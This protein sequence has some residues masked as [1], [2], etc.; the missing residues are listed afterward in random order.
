M[1]QKGIFGLSVHTFE[2]ATYTKILLTTE[3]MSL[4]GTGVK[5]TL[6]QGGGSLCHCN[7]KK[8]MGTV[9]ND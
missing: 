3:N 7:K 2:S 1:E 8:K 6:G 9:I 4:G 5:S